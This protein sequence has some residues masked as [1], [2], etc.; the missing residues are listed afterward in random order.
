MLRSAEVQPLF[1]RFVWRQLSLILSI[2]DMSSL[3]IHL[4]PP[5]HKTPYPIPP[6]ITQ[7]NVYCCVSIVIHNNP[8][9][10]WQHNTMCIVVCQRLYTNPPNNISIYPYSP[11]PFLITK[12]IGLV[13]CEDYLYIYVFIALS[14]SRQQLFLLNHYYDYTWYHMVSYPY[15]PP[16]SF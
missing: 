4:P 13:Y 10:R 2:P 5:I 1:W 15:S 9:P 12:R 7:H 16:S 3:P 6:L 11:P 14:M 8:C